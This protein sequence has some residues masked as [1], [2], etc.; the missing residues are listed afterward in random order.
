MKILNS[1]DQVYHSLLLDIKKNGYNKGDRTGTGT[2][3]VFG[4]QIRFNLKDGFPLLT[5]KK[6]HTKSVIHELLWFLKGDTNIKYLNDN[7][8]TIW[9]EWADSKGDLGPVYGKQWV[10]WNSYQTTVIENSGGLLESIS[11]VTI[12]QINQIQNAVERLKNSPD[13]RRILIS[14]LNIA[15]MPKMKLPPCHYGFQLWSRDLSLEERYQLASDYEFAT[16]STTEE[17]EEDQHKFL[18]KN[19]IPRRELSLMWNQR[20]VDTFLG[21]PFNIASYAFLLHMFAQQ[22]NMSPGELI[23][24]LGDTHLY[25]NHLSYVDEQLNRESKGELPTLKLNKAKSIFDYTYDD[26]ELLNYTPHPNWKNVPI[27]V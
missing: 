10:A 4:R 22:T 15:D 16:I 1:T 26:F 19:D 5:T 2:K 20:S 27:A 13:C 18:D 25:L 3:S 23:A 7:G 17:T 9:D 12:T 11:I 14:A 24:N 8:V 6:I 21:L